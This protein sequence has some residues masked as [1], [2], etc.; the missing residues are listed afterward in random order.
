[1]SAPRKV[2]SAQPMAIDYLFE[3]FDVDVDASVSVSEF[4]SSSFLSFGK[5]LSK[6]L[7]FFG[8]NH[9]ESFKSSS[10]SLRLP[11]L[12]L[13]EEERVFTDILWTSCVE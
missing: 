10:L 6:P 7:P 9:K 5:K 1:M 4:S 12:L 3:T 11:L 13:N 8:I 2:L